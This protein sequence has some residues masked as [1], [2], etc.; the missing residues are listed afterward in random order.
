MPSGEEF[1]DDFIDF[2]WWIGEELPSASRG[3]SSSPT[4]ENGKRKQPQHDD[5]PG[6]GKRRYDHQ[7]LHAGM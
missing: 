3:I 5:H 6:T 4:T 2:I 7:M 1:Y